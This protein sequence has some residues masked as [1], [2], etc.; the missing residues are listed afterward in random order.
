MV[1]A[2]RRG[3]KHLAVAIGK[4]QVGIAYRYILFSSYLFGKI[5][6]GCKWNAQLIK[7]F[8]SGEFLQWLYK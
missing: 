7:N 2:I 6:R 1:Y 8:Y 3:A 4:V 5:F